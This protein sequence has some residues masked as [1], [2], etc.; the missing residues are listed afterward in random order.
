MSGSPLSGKSTVTKQIK[1][2][3]EGDC[4]IVS[5]DNIRK[6]ITG[7]YINHTQEN[8]VWATVIK[9]ILKALS[10]GKVAVLDATLR[11]KDLRMKHLEY[12]KDYP[13]YYIAFEKID[14]N[15][16]LERNDDRTWK[17]LD[18]TILKKLWE[19]YEVPT[20][21]EMSLYKKAV[22]INNDNS[23]DKVAELLKYVQEQRKESN[24]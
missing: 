20:E 22:L 10:K 21:E 9:R 24:T 7:D 3:L 4:V 12:Y 19:E 1:R 8:A 5:T 14:L 23:N 13:I 11:Q 18:E 6:E 2:L 17:H 16:L 15:V